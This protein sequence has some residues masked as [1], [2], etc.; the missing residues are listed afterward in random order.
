[1]NDLHT[2]DVVTMSVQFR[3]MPASRPIHQWVQKRAER[4]NRFHLS[5]G[6]CEAVIDKTQHWNKGG[7][8]KVCVRFKVPGERLFVAIVEEEGTS[9]D[10]LYSAVRVAFDEIER[11]LKKQRTK[12][13]RRR[14]TDVAA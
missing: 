1:M 14:L 13:Y 12:N 8:L 9:Y 7:V 2:P 6:H 11:Q 10:F 4:L 3:H 5:G